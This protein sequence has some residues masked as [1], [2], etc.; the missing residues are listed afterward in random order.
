[1]STSW[2]AGGQDLIDKVRS[3]LPNESAN[4]D[5]SHFDHIEAERQAVPF[6]YDDDPDLPD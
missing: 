3:R 4:L 1:M 5:D 2:R 6:D